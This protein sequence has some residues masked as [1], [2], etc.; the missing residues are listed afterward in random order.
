MSRLNAIE[1][2]DATGKAKELLNAVKAKL[3]IVPNMT[4]VMANS[5]A[6][7][8]G[9][10]GFSGAL[11]T[12]LLDARTREQLALVT[13]QSN[14]CDYCLSAHTAIGKMVG[15]KPEEIADS[16]LGHSSNARTS[17]A[18]KF[19]TEVLDHKGAISVAD[20]ADVR[21]AGFSDG[22]IAEIIAHVA[23]NVLTNYFNIAT[24]VEIDFPKVSFANAT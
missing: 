16:R 12:G 11:G 1:P 4:K 24:D 20:I 23:L 14:H 6:V 8:E 18:L 17:A 15:L 3:G 21:A 13:A 9:Y 19:A 10:L 22:E 2:T 5:P 7:L